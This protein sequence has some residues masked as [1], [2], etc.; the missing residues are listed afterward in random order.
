MSNPQT[1]ADNALREILER[2]WQGAPA[3]VLR[4]PPG[5][6]TTGVAQRVAL[7]SARPRAL[8]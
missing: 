1:L 2:Q 5:A 4:S 7:H 6:G 8:R 3:L